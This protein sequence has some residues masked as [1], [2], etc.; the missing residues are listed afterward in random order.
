M[1]LV[2]NRRTLV[3]CT[4]LEQSAASSF[5]GF[6]GSLVEAFQSHGSLYL[7]GIQLQA[8]L[9]EMTILNKINFLAIHEKFIHEDLVVR[10]IKDIDINFSFTSDV[11]ATY[12]LSVVFLTDGILKLDNSLSKFIKKLVISLFEFC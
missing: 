7:I 10:F 1:V 5:L 3:N 4:S 6:F 11:K 9:F 2:N 12:F 8:K